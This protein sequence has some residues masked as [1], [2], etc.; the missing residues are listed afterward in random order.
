MMTHFD[1]IEICMICNTVFFVHTCVH[2]YVNVR[3]LHK[4]AYRLRMCQVCW[5]W[6]VAIMFCC[7]YKCKIWYKTTGYHYQLA[8]L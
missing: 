3:A 1:T 8:A 7:I 5:T 6:H 2:V 4:H